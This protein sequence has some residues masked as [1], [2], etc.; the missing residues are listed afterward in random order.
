MELKSGNPTLKPGIF[1][2]LAKT[3]LEGDRMSLQGT[4]NKVGLMLLTVLLSAA[5]IW[6]RFS[7][8]M[9]FVSVAPLFYIGLFGGFG[10]SLIIIFKKDLAPNLALVYAVLEG[11]ALGG[12]S[13]FMESLYPRIVAQAVVLTFGTFT[14]LLALYQFRVIKVTARFRLMVFSATGGIAIYYLLS[15]VLSFFGIR[16]PLI[17]DSGMYGILFSLL[18]VAVA[19]MNL[20]LDFDFIEQGVLAGAPKYMEWYGAFGL[21]VTLVWLYIEILRLLSKTRRR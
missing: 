16:M 17:H 12:V 11:L 20:V 3:G 18:V 15:F 8:T 13:A 19:A 4:V 2:G 1:E 10:V 14:A 21:M 9:D 5:F 7:G 6:Y